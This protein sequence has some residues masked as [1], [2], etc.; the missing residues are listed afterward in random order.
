MAETL[1]NSKDCNDS[2]PI[3]RGKKSALLIECDWLFQCENCHVIVEAVG[4]ELW[5]GDDIADPVLSAVSV[6]VSQVPLS[7]PDLELSRA[8]GA[9][10]GVQGAVGGGDDVSGRDQGAAAPKLP[11]AVAQQV[12]GHHPRILA[13]VS[14]IAADYA[15]LGDFDVTAT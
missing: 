15:R 3:L 6:P 5:V 4:P 7:Y 14:R 13:L 10:L 8:E 1:R 12:D 2:S 11:L 9:F